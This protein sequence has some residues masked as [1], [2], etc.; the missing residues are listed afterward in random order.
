MA[1]TASDVSVVDTRPLSVSSH[2]RNRLLA[3]LPAEDYRRL[4]PFLETV[5]LPF[6]S[7]L[8]KPDESVQRILFPGGGVCSIVW[9]MSDGQM[10][11]IATI[12]SEGLVGIS[13]FFGGDLVAGETL[14]QVADDEAQAM[15]VRVF[16]REMERRGAL[17]DVVNRYA[18][19][20]VAGLM[21][22][23]ACNA[24]HPIENRCA[25]WLIETH[26]RVGRDEFP[27]TQEFLAM[28]LGVRRASVTLCVGALHRAGLVDYGH[29][30][31]VIR[32]RQG[33]EAASCEC[34]AV[35]KGYFARLLP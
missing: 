15:D 16:Q 26:D 12:G 29:R 3:R 2:S 32:N 10:V 34:Y 31:I 30:R 21:Q 5:S 17:Y 25:R 19:V 24:L 8:Q 22:G 14:V 9:T 11:E 13:A 7:V 1:L 35:V 28:M 6:Q 33:L 20:F 27:M 4:A 18:Q 23:V